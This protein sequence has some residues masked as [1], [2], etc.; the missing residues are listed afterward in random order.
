MT[1]TLSVERITGN[2]V[3]GQRHT[4]TLPKAIRQMF[5]I[6]VGDMLR[7]EVGDDCLVMRKMQLIPA[8][9]ELK[10]VADRRIAEIARGDSV[11]IED[12]ESGT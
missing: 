8:R 12:L 5:G 2:I 9:S 1:S 7:L 10:M 11:T 6:E 4:I 3:V